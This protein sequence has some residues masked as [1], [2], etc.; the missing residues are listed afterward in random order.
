MCPTLR[1][2]IYLFFIIFGLAFLC[3]ILL[4]EAMIMF[5]TFTRSMSVRALRVMGTGRLPELT[6]RKGPKYHHVSLTCALSLP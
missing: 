4:V 5:Y 1:A 3:L 6:L 2:G